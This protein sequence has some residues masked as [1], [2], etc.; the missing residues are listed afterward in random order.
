MR[1][2]SRPQ[3]VGNTSSSEINASTETHLNT[4]KQR[5]KE[6][7]SRKEENSENE[8]LSVE[9]VLAASAHL[10]KQCSK[11]REQQFYLEE[12]EK[13]RARESDKEAKRVTKKRRVDKQVQE[14]KA[15]AF[16]VIPL[17]ETGY[18][19]TLPTNG[20]CFIKSRMFENSQTFRSNKMLLPSRASGPA[21][22]FTS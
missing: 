8:P 3:L 19:P 7:P 9:A 6:N 21:L 11:S 20:S 10:Q 13:R 17:E 1:T 16:T 2:R 18:S 15:G 22:D 4:N 14:T 12:A 5:A